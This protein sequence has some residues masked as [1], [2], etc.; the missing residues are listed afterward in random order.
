MVYILNTHRSL[1]IEL[2]YIDL[3]ED[4]K[5]NIKKLFLNQNGVWS[6]KGRKD[7]D[8]AEH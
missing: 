3:L 6:W 7:G 5:L 1:S 4:T 2:I 8:C